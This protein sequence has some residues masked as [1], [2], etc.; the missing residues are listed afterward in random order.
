MRIAL[1]CILLVGLLALL[2]SSRSV[3]G[4]LVGTI[5]VPK[6]DQTVVFVDGVNGA[7]PAT[8][9][10]MDQKGKVFTPYVLPVVK[11][12]TVAFRNHDNLQHNVFSVGADE[13]NLGTFGSGDVREHTFNKLGDA[14]ILCNVHPEM[15]AHVLVLSNPYFAQPD[16]NGKFHI[17]GVPAGDYVIKAWYA[18]K[19]KKQNVKV[20]AGG[21]ITVNF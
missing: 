17:T 4:D 10:E 20:P 11:G 16:G 12:S 7:F 8:R 14:A 2:A 6:P 5:T 19:I 15:E 3:A 13:F 21:S 1:R 9:A 18:G